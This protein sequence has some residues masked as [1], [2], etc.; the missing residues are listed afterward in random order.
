MRQA[1]RPGGQVSRHRPQAGG[2]QA[3]Q[4][5]LAFAATAVDPQGHGR[6]QVVGGD[7]TVRILRPLAMNGLEQPG[8]VTGGRGPVEV[9]QQCHP[10]AQEAPQYRIDHAFCPG[11][12]QRAG[13]PNRGCHGG[14]IGDAHALQLVEAAKQQPLDV[15]VPVAQGPG[16]ELLQYPVQLRLL[17]QGAV[18]QLLQQAA[19]ARRDLLQVLRQRLVERFAGDD[20][21]DHPGRGDAC[22]QRHQSRPL[23][24]VAKRLPG[25]NR[26]A[27]AFNSCATDRTLPPASCSCCRLSWLPSQLTRI[28]SRPDRRMVPGA[29]SAVLRQPT[30][31]ARS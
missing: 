1:N 25:A 22:I 10:L 24:T 12:V 21:A 20:L 4:V 11:L 5:V 6:L 7:D 27:R 14:V 3:P 30:V 18:A 8:G 13:C 17:S 9:C 19:V 16:E 29:P 26:S 23:A 31:P 2:L 28:P 15:A